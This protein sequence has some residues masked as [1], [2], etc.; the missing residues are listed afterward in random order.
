MAYEKM[1]KISNILFAV[2]TIIVYALGLCF[3]ISPD[4]FIKH[5]SGAAF[6][7]YGVLALIIKCLE[8]KYNPERSFGKLSKIATGIFIVLI[9]IRCI[10]I[11]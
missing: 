3:I 1:K 6:V 10:F 4:V 7:V 9:I 2:W 11:T 8:D 5:C